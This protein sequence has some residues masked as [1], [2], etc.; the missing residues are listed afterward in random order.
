VP[1]NGCPIHNA[2]RLKHS[3]TAPVAHHSSTQGSPAQVLIA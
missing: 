1:S 2:S 3:R